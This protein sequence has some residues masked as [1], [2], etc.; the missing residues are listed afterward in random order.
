MTSERK[1]RIYDRSIG[2]ICETPL[3]LLIAYFSFF[4]PRTPSP[5]DGHKW[6]WYV[7]ILET[8][9]V[10]L[11]Y[12]FAAMANNSWSDTV[13][14]PVLRYEWDWIWERRHGLSWATREEYWAGN[15]YLE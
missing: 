3:E 13:F 14:R 4:S 7:G 8:A 2:V 10:H 11:R 12:A 6:V 5:R 9:P 15:D 1:R